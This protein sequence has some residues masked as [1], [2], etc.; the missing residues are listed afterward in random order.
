MKNETDQP[1][2]FKLSHETIEQLSSMSDFD[3][4]GL[5]AY[6]RA[7]DNVFFQYMIT[8]VDQ[9]NNIGISSNDI[10]CI[11]EVKKLLELLQ[12]TANENETA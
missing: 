2:T 4:D 9:N 1:Q 5:N 12:K 7:I 6:S 3:Y 8:V 11:Q 10:F